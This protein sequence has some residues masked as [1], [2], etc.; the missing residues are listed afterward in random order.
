[1]ACITLSYLSAQEDKLENL[2]KQERIAK[3]KFR[4]TIE[5][6][7]SKLLKDTAKTREK[8]KPM[9]KLERTIV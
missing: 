3:E 1:M 6:I 7:I 5:E 8:L 2:R 9:N 4:K